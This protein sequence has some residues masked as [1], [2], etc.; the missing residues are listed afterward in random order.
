MQKTTFYGLAIFAII[1]VGG[2]MLTKSNA[3]TGIT[4]NVIANGVPSGA[5]QEVV[6]GMKDF[7]YF[8]QEIKVKSGQTVKISADD[9][10]Y[11]CFKD[12][13]VRDLG[14]RNYF[15]NAGDSFEFT[16]AEKGTYTFSCG[17]GMG[18][19]KLIVE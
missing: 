10:L 8:P 3:D 12:F 7:N 11:G 1:V 15:K 17:M 6:L 9:T 19:G 13:T 2:F 14:V 16:P 18:S 5:I 4:G